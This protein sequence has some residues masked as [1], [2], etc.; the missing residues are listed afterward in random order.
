MERSLPGTAERRHIRWI[1]LIFAYLLS[2]M[3]PGC[4]RGPSVH[5]VEGTVTLDGQPL[6]GATVKF[7]P[8][9]GGMPAAGLTDGKGVYRLNPLRAKPQTGTTTGGYA[10]GIHKYENPF[11]NLPPPPAN[12]AAAFERHQAEMSRLSQLPPV[13][14]TPQRY[15][16][17]RTSGLSATVKTGRNTIDF[18]LKGDVKGAAAR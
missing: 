8:L 15:F 16:D 4:S 17:G 1:S 10:V 6:E 5:Y 2:I 11:K 18:D 9:D 3:M 13:F 7:E 12:D 14:I